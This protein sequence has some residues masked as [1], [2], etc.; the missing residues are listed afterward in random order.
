MSAADSA[1]AIAADVRAGTRS[2]VDV[3]EAHLARIEATEPEVHAF[4]EVT[5]EAAR[6]AA[7]DVDRR[8]AAGDR[9]GSLAA[10]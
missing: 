2:A 4:N 8:G 10:S 6:A 7:V 9:G 3:V 5:A 1:L